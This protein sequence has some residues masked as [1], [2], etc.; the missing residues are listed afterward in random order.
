MTDGL[1]SNY[2]ARGVSDRA[3]LIISYEDRTNDMLICSGQTF[4]TNN[5]IVPGS[6]YG[7]ITNKFE[8]SE[9]GP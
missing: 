1:F 6:G 4:T 9:I 3:D 8:L 2:V 5:V 7:N